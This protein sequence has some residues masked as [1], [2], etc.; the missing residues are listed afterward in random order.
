MARLPNAFARNWRL[1]LSALG[2]SIFLWALVQTEPLSQETFSSVPVFV[3]IAD[4][5]WTTAGAPDPPTVELR[6]GGP[7]REIIR[8]AREGTSVLIPVTA[9][10]SRDTI[11]AV[12][13]DWVQLGQR[14]GVTVET[15][16]PATLRVSFERAVTKTMPLAMRI[17]G[18]LP[19]GLALSNE[20]ELDP[21]S[22]AV[23]GPESR[24]S[25]LDT[26][27]LEPLDLGR[28][29][30]SDLFTLA[31]DTT[32]LAGATVVPS[33]AMVGVRVE[34]LVERD[35]EASI[36]ADVRGPGPGVTVEPASIRLRLSG[37]RTLVVAMDLSL[38]RVS[39]P[40]E[41]L[42]AMVPGEERLVRL[43][44]DG[45]P[46]LVTALPATEVVTVRRAVDQPGQVEQDPS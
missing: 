31:V 35:I 38:V 36:H 41:S 43:R 17:L 18:E 40:A 26:I 11:I 21:E 7:A 32:G 3:D 9:V 25:G 37:A 15:V 5:A 4:T 12:Q 24:L 10:G 33:S 22:V 34:P 46:S 29:R 23:R 39:V 8:L 27:R 42:V 28:V 44:I 45:V 2:L 13:R 20:L 1:K 16:S 14:P 6:L 30:D 19:A